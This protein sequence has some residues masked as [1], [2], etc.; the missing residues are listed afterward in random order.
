MELYNQYPDLFTHDEFV[1]AWKGYLDMRK[2]IKKPAT[3]RAEELGIGQVIR[4]SKGDV[5]T[6]VKIVDQST[7]KSWQGLFPLREDLNDEPAGQRT[8]LKIGD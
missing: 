3:L 1:K 5:G 2:L 8:T 7:F 4:L 6:A